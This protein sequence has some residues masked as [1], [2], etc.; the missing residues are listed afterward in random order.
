M[1]EPSTVT[2]SSQVTFVT[3]VIELTCDSS[4][5]DS[6]FMDDYKDMIIPVESEE[7]RELNKRG[8][9]FCKH[10]NLDFAIACF[11]QAIKKGSVNA[12]NSIAACYEMQGDMKLAERY[13]VGAVKKGNPIALCNLG[14]LYASQKR[15]DIATLYLKPFA[16]AGKKKANYRLGLL[17]LER[18]QY[19]LANHYLLRAGNSP[20]VQQ[21]LQA[22]SSAFKEQLKAT[23][24]NKKSKKRKRDSL[25]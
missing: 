6:P 7:L 25:S 15:Y 12:L 1:E 18:G 8:F 9:Y 2:P 4:T 5:A 14:M 16:L 23:L 20:L 22:M 3:N 21:A 10:N 11:D 24:C 19:Q 17:Y 13:Y